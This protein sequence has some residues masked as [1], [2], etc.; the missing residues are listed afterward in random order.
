MR[1][2]SLGSPRKALTPQ[3]KEKR[4]RGQR[5]APSLKTTLKL[6]GYT[7]GT[8]R[9]KGEKCTQKTNPVQSQ[10]S[11]TLFVLKTPTTTGTTLTA[12]VRVGCFG[13]ETIGL[14]QIVQILVHLSLR[15]T[16]ISIK[17]VRVG[18]HSNLLWVMTHSIQEGFLF[19]Q[20]K[21]RDL[22]SHPCDG[23]LLILT[24]T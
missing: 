22:T 5:K 17:I 8:E 7:G 1:S 23:T 18:L 16:Q 24:F 21:P 19:L 6:S 12:F 3:S 20:H 9:N 10:S 13:F 14:V 4:K 15:Y 11:T 2:N